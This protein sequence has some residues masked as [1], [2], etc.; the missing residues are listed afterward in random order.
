MLD[1]QKHIGQTEALPHTTYQGAGIILCMGLANEKRRYN[2]TPSL[3]GW[4]P[5]QNEY[6]QRITHNTS[7]KYQQGFVVVGFALFMV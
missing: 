6:M 5:T 1:T 3:I 7:H 4:A 2:I